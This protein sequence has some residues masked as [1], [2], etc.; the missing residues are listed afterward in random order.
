M[1]RLQ[2]K[3]PQGSPGEQSAATTMPEVGGLIVI[4]ALLTVLSII[5]V[6]SRS[7]HSGQFYVT[8]SRN[9]L[10]V[11][12]AL[13]VFLVVSRVNV[14][15]ILNRHA[16]LFS[17][18]C[19]LNLMAVISGSTIREGG[20]GET[21]GLGIRVLQLPTLTLYSLPVMLAPALVRRHG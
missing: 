1:K 20:A 13:A 6:G 10:N 9:V 21:L 15:R 17:V 4:A 8:P 3:T 11:A 16:I 5:V 14:N 7:L 19:F 18:V 2:D 12:L